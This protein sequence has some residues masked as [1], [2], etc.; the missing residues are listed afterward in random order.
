MKKQHILIL[1]FFLLAVTTFLAAYFMMRSAELE[2]ELEL[3]RTR[4]ASEYEV[5][6]AAFFTQ[7]VATDSLLLKENYTDALLAYERLSQEIRKDHPMSQDVQLRIFQVRQMEGMRAKLRQ[8]E[9]QVPDSGVV[10]PTPQVDSLVT[11]LAVAERKRR[12]QYDSLHFALEK[13]HL[14]AASLRHLLSNPSGSDYLKFTDAN[15]NHIHYVGE[16]TEFKANGKGI[17]LF[18]T[19]CRYEGAW[20]DNMR[21]GEGTFYWADGEHYE[22]SFQHNERH[23]LGDYYWPNG[24]KFSGEWKNDK[25]NGPGT[26]YSKDGKTVV[27]G[28]WK[29]NKLVEKNRRDSLGR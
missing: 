24:D 4:M 5:E 20:S 11:R 12:D 26:F 28:V 6:P 18:H 2:E 27:S 13:A 3:S 21:H 25:R 29:N 17:G 15:G 7:L 8:L 22:G 1:T 23:G 14:Q 19:G 16:V 10:V 9:E